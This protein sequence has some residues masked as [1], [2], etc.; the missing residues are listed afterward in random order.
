MWLLL[1]SPVWNELQ[2]YLSKKQREARAKDFDKRREKCLRV[3][4]QALNTSQRIKPKRQKKFLK[5]K[6]KQY[7]LTKKKF[8]ASNQGAYLPKYLTSVAL[9][10]FYPNHCLAYKVRLSE[11]IS[12]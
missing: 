8:L 12:Q 9:D 11:A 4:D 10:T 3:I 1:R 7:I 2:V 5:G 6:K